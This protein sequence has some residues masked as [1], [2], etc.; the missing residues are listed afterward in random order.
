MSR[1]GARALV[2]FL[3][4]AGGRAWL[5]PDQSLVSPGRT[6]SVVGILTP[7]ASESVGEL[8]GGR[9]CDRRAVLA[10][11]PRVGTVAAFL[12][13]AASP[14]VVA[15]R[16]VLPCRAVV[17]AEQ[18]LTLARC[19]YLILRVQEATQQVRSY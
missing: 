18:P 15:G 19:V 16:A 4:A 9:R 17:T 6:R 14:E 7:G 2:A 10:T 5:L 8:P 3:V 11:A 12:L 1:P 13:G